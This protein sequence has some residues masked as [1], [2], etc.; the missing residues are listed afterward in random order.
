MT[1]YLVPPEHIAEVWGECAPWIAAAIAR[2]QGDEGLTDV[3]VAL[4]RGAYLLWYSPG[5]YATVAQIQRF[6]KQTVG[7]V[8]Y[9]GGHD[10][11]DMKGAFDDAKA[12]CRANGIKVMRIWGRPGWARVLDMKPVGVILQCEVDP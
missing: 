11:E 9:C 1:A 4:A 6:P 5:K 7:M 3:L 8:L 12:W 10:L 2:N